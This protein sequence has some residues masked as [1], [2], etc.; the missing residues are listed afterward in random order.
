MFEDN[1]NLSKEFEAFFIENYPK[2]KTFARHLLMREQDA[3][4]IA[5]DIFLKIADR[6]AIWRDPEQSGKYLFTMTKNYI[7]NVIKHRNI[8][9]KHEVRA[10]IENNIAEEFELTDG[11]HAHEIELLLQHAIEQLPPQ[12][13]EVFLLSRIEGL[14]HAAI[15]EKTHLSVRTVERHLY[16]ALKDLKKMLS[17]LAVL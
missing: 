15:A 10:K 16:L 2:V 1:H 12:R 4:D 13:K 17:S 8:E 3:E 14:S 7:F 11:L 6:P 5:Q 9:R